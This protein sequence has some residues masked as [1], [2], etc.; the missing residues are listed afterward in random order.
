MPI[1]VANELSA[2]FDLAGTSI[3]DLVITPAESLQLAI[4]RRTCAFLGPA[5]GPA[6]AIQRRATA[7]TY[8]AVRQGV[9]AAAKAGA[10]TA[11]LATG[12]NFNVLTRS[13]RGRAANSAL[14]ALAGDVLA[15]RSSALAIPMGVRANGASVDCERDDLRSAYPKATG[16]IA[17]FIHGLGEIPESWQRR[18][19]PTFGAQLLRDF[20]ITAVYVEYNTG[21]HIA[22]NGARLS[23]LV[24][25][26]RGSTGPPPL[27]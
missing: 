8:G 2:L 19:R 14:N 23:D 13:R 17:V 1:P 27:S 21:L 9:R 15:E 16:R 3:D 4:T 24:D 10:G 22:K 26:V 7:T 20:G 12:P 25:I 5:A 18:R 11:M 6:F